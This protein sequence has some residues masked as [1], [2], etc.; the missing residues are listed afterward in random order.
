MK[1]LLDTCVLIPAEPTDV[2]EIEPDTGVIAL[3]QRV[4]QERG[5][6]TYV[7]PDSLEELAH[8]RLDQRR[9]ARELLIRRYLTL[10]RPPAVTLALE[11]LVG[12]AS[13]G[14]H[15]EFDN[16]LL[17]AI[18]GD[19]VDFLVTSDTGLLKKAERAGLSDRVGTP[20]EILK[21]L[22]GKRPKKAPPRPGVINVLSYELDGQDAIFN[23]LRNEYK[24]FDG[25][26]AKCK[27]E[28][29]PSW[30]VKRADGSYG[31]V[32]IIKDEQPGAYGLPGKVLKICTFVAE[33]G[34][35]YGELLLKAVFDHAFLNSYDR[36][37]LEVYPKHGDVIQ[38]LRKF[39]FADLGNE[40]TK[41]ERVLVK[42]LSCTSVEREGLAPLEYNIQ[43]GPQRVKLEGAPA[44]VIPIQSG[45]HRV[46]FP[47]AGVQRNLFS[48]HFPFGNAI[49]KAYLCHSNIKKVTPG[50]L[51][52][53]YQSR[54]NQG[55]YCVGVSENS[56]RS[57]DPQQILNFV[58]TR[59]VYSIGE[60]EKLCER[61]VLAILFRHALI[62][63][64]EWSR[65]HLINGG[66]IAAPPQSIVEVPQEAHPWLK[67]QLSKWL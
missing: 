42:A 16:R 10:E 23:Q 44:F 9:Q 55:V 3:L 35:G 2:T 22:E 64:K 54:H 37:Y 66:V 14:S 20:I 63:E 61:E 6:Q 1:L 5:E 45:Y 7:H 50:A 17:A 59:T 32:S 15:A 8:D 60:I 26:F 24:S 53:F 36:L 47:E 67:T 19:A 40:S 25:W 28:H 30:V 29:R 39:G 49:R 12:S 38:L 58:G 57:R 65:T 27:R 18:F 62:L 13:P 4:C 43:C 31:A 34:R 11:S 41:G 56:I 46:L 51:L 52:L 48:G 21:R 33:F